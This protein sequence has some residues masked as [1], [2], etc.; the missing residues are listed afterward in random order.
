MAWDAEFVCNSQ[1]IV[2]KTKGIS[3]NDAKAIR[4]LFDEQHSNLHMKAGMSPERTGAVKGIMVQKL[5]FMK[6]RKI[7]VEIKWTTQGVDR[8]NRPERTYFWFVKYL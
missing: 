7:E 2:V 3:V 1:G 6:A 8:F 4:Y 5:G